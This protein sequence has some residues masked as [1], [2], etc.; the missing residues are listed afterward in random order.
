MLV[1]RI[2]RV[3]RGYAG[4]KQFTKLLIKLN[5]DIRMDYYNSQA[6]LIQK[7]WRGYHSRRTIFD[8]YGRKKYLVEVGQKVYLIL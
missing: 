6:T 2:Q 1:K 8:Y 3:Y 4:R 7:V 5:K